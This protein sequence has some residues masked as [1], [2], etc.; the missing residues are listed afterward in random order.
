MKTLETRQF[1]HTADR[2]TAIGLGGAVLTQQTF[3][4]GVQTVRRAYEL[5]IRYF[6]TSPGYCQN[7]S[8]PVIG[9]GLAGIPTDS[10]AGNE[11][12][13]AT[14]VGYF[15]DPADF[16]SQDAIRR[17]IEDNLRLLRRDRVDVL[18]VHEANMTCWWEEGAPS[19]WIQ[20][21]DERAYDFASAPVLQ[22]LRKAKEEGLCRYIGITGN[23]AHQMSRVLGAVEIDTFLVAFSY[24]LV[25]R[26]AE[27]EAFPLAEQKKVALILGAIFYGGRLVRVREEWLS[28]PP[29]WMTPAL[30]ERFARLYRIQRECGIPLPQLALRYVLARDGVSVILIG[31]KTPAEIEESVAA[32]QAG[33]LPGDLQARVDELGISAGTAKG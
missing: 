1:G 27:E 6:D 9:E 13:V 26:D 2:T 32:V 31:A 33:P 19:P 17:Q 28:E 21:Q 8:Q 29:E 23:V 12:M 15:K 18:Q 11:L 10:A 14:K 25:V 7:R 3:E 20:I 30:T 22:A 5:G 16:R 4:A 24:D